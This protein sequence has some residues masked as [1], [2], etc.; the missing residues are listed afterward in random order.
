MA[1]VG[2][3]N[4]GLTL[5]NYLDGVDSSL[6]DKSKA[7]NLVKQNKDWT[8]AHLEWRVHVQ[9]SGAIGGI[10]D[11]GAL[12]VANKQTY[13]TAK[14]GRR[15]TA[16]SIQLTDAVMATASKSKFV[17][18]D[19][20]ES[21]ME[22]LMTEFLKFENGMLFRNG[23]GSVATVQTGSSGT[24]LIVD[25]ARMLW[26]GVTY[27]IY[28]STLATNRGQ[29]SI[30]STASDPTA[31][32]Y[33]TVTTSTL[34]SGTTA[35][36]VVVWKGTVNKAISGLD[37][38]ISDSGTVQNIL[39]T[40]YPRHTSLVLDSSSARALTPTLFRQMQ[41]GLYEKSGADDPSKV[42][43]VIGSAW[44]MLNVDEL[45]ESELRVTADSKTGGLSMPEFQSS[46]GRFRVMPDADAKF[47]TLF[48]VDFSQIYRGTQ[49]KLGWR[50]EK[51]GS[52]FKRSDTAAVHTATALE[53][54]E[55]YI[56]E[57][58]TSGKIEDLTES[59]KATVY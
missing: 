46:F 31:S 56:R 11:G 28:D 6:N 51:N 39:A 16:G 10:D 25:D 45:F 33:A 43:T 55:L 22:G 58:I 9:R 24:T 53:I 18:K 20:V 8:G 1:G 32:G 59:N 34:P 5:I 49:K 15:M 47:G 2:V 30:T 23:D 36:D 29:F 38:L 3:D 21:E 35:T 50:V 14:V 27:E 19:V 57:R 52:I 44:Q 40:T 41:A 4:V 37:K 42:L 26:D 48:F 13:A 17:A 12:P 7:R 54:A